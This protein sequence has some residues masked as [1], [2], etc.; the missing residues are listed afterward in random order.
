VLA[1][2]Y[3]KAGRLDDARRTLESLSAGEGESAAA[4]RDLLARLPR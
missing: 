4:A 1:N 3:L 2:A